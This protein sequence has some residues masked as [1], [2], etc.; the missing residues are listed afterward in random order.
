MEIM[1]KFYPLPRS[2]VGP[3]HPTRMIRIVLCFCLLATVSA[4]GSSSVG[5]RNSKLFYVS[6]TTKTVSYTTYCFAKSVSTGSSLVACSKKRKRRAMTADTN[7]EVVQENLSQV[8]GQDHQLERL[9]VSCWYISKLPTAPKIRCRRAMLMPAKE[10]SWCT[11]WRRPPPPRLTSPPPLSGPSNVL[12]AHSIW[13]IA[14]TLLSGGF[15]VC[16]SDEYQASS[17]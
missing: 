13:S 10:S 7:S 3:R 12:P 17:G 11:G 6:S 2:P 14:R 15:S 5:T 16:C 4:A 9:V 8:T 1:T